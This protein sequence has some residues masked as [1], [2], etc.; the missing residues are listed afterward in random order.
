MRK[1]TIL[2]LSFLISTITYSQDVN[3]NVRYIP[4]SQ[5]PQSVLD[6][7]G[8]LFPTN[9]VSEWQVQEMDG[10]QDAQNIG[11]YEKH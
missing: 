1:I 7:Q 9:F 6:R 2:L 4:E 11:S 3:N 8:D 10:M 5:V